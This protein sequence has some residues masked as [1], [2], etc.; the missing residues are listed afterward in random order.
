MLVLLISLSIRGSGRLL[1]ILKKDK[2]TLSCR[3]NIELIL[4]FRLAN[5]RCLYFVMTSFIGLV[6][7]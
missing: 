5:E 3:D 4:G 6:Q 1:C 2:T 7:A